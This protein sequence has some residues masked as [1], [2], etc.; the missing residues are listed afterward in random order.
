MRK[1][2]ALK[3]EYGYIKA[4]KKREIFKT[5]LFFAL[6]ALFLI[7]GIAIMK[8]RNPDLTFSQSRNNLLTIGSVLFI[9]PA[10]KF[11][12]STIMFARAQKYACT[13]DIRDMVLKRNDAAAF[14]VYLTSYQKDFP[15]YA[16][17]CTENEIAGLSADAAIDENAAKEHILQVLKKDGYRNVTVKIFKDREKFLERIAGMDTAGDGRDGSLKLRGLILDVSL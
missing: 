17:V 12:V 4:Q 7:A 1:R 9:L 14:D 16:I 8:S 13:E 15:L 5:A 3:G 2:S 11:L 10:A 6:S